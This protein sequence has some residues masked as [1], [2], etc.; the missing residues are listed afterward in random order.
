MICTGE[1]DR[2]SLKGSASDVVDMAAADF[3]RVR[4][5]GDGTVAK[6]YSHPLPKAAE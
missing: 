3:A 2:A 6:W 1:E 5:P 4:C